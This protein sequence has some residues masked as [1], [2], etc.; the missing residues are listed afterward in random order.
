MSFTRREMY[1]LLPA[2]LLRLPPSTNPRT[3]QIP[4]FRSIPVRQ[5]DARGQQQ[6]AGPDDV[7]GKAG[8]RRGRRVHPRPRAP[9]ARLAPRIIIT[10]KCG[11]WEGTIELTVIDKKFRLEPGQLGLS[12]PTKSTA[13]ER[14][15]DARFVLC[16][17]G[18]TRRGLQGRNASQ[19]RTSV[20]AN[21]S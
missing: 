3:G 6:R 16:G 21:P 2:L 20:I 19:R 10:L 11:S 1:L 14:G 5:H 8:Y 17:R 7:S 4:A 9:P 12:P 15:H 13:S 18:W